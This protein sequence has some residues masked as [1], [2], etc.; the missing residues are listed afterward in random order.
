MVEMVVSEDATVGAL[1]VAPWATRSLS[2]LAK[3]STVSAELTDEGTATKTGFKLNVEPELVALFE[4]LAM[5]SNVG[6]RFLAARMG[7][8][9]ASRLRMKLGTSAPLPPACWGLP[10]PVV[11]FTDVCNGMTMCCGGALFAAVGIISC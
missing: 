3:A 2:F 9:S 5:E 4:L 7:E 8:P 6:P 10:A 11:T 1:L